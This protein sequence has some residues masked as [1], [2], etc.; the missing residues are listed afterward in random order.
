ML[1][2]IPS[3]DITRSL[4]PFL[5]AALANCFSFLDFFTTALSSS[6]IS[7]SSF[8][9]GGITIPSMIS[10]H[11]L[12]SAITLNFRANSCQLSFKLLDSSIGSPD[13]YLQYSYDLTL[14]LV[15]CMSR[16]F[17]LFNRMFINVLKNLC[18]RLGLISSCADQFSS[19]TLFKS[20]IACLHVSFTAYE[21]FYKLSKSASFS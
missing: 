8:S 1:S 20:E 4:K 18:S 6:V 12:S 10:S 17:S 9:S 2:E 14:S 3:V 13:Q 11:P 16:V 19:C 5:F 15:G 21:Y 7:R